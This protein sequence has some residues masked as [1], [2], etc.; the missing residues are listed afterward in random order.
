M[1]PDANFKTTWSSIFSRKGGSGETTRLWDDWD[2]DSRAAVLGKISF[3][4]EE[5]PVLLAHS[6]AGGA[7]LLTTRRLICDAGSAPVREVVGVEAAKF[8]ENRK[9]QLTELDVELST[10]RSLRVAVQSGS[11]YFA[12]WSVLLNIARRNAHRPSAS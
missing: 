9:D 12:L 2:D 7:T 6:K 5:L 1:N 10:G 8:T 3:E 4:P 11:S